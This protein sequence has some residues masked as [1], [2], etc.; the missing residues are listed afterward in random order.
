MAVSQGLRTRLVFRPNWASPLSRG[1]TQASQAPTFI[2][3][4]L[5]SQLR[6]ELPTSHLINY[7]ATGIH[8]K[9]KVNV[10]HIELYGFDQAREITWIRYINSSY[11]KFTLVE[12]YNYLHTLK[13]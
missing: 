12:P 8:M 4:K 9:N 2:A 5:N 1:Q 6:T 10:Y 11:R 7:Y 3:S 13:I